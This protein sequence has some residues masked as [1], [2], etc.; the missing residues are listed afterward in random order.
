MLERE[1]KILERYKHL[2][3]E[4]CP[5]MRNDIK[6][7]TNCKRGCGHTAQ[8]LRHHVTNSTECLEFIQSTTC[9]DRME[10]LPPSANITQCHGYNNVLMPKFWKKH[11]NVF[12]PR[13]ADLAP[14]KGKILQSQE[15]IMKCPTCRALTRFFRTKEKEKCRRKLTTISEGWPIEF[16]FCDNFEFT[17]DQNCD[18]VK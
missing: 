11:V 14:H 9:N 17:E 16:S 18:L 15:I 13:I 5:I 2:D 3:H 8:I 10:C 1:D 7:V 6:T 4:K 12:A